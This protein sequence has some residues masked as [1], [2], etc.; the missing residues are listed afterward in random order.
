MALSFSKNV[1]Y[2]YNAKG[3]LNGIGTNLIGS[4]AN[5]TTNVISGL[6]YQ[7]DAANR[8]KH[9]KGGALSIYG[10]DGNGKRVK[11]SESGTMGRRGWSVVSGGW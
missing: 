10:Y 8:L 7:W 11:K 2:A 6:T 4:N 1:N 9:V 3:A 5:A